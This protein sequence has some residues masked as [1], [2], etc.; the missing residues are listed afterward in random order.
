MA[1][2]RFQALGPS[3]WMARGVE[4]HFRAEMG[5][6]VRRRARGRGAEVAGPQFHRGGEELTPP[7]AVLGAVA[8]PL[9]DVGEQALGLNVAWFG[10]HHVVEDL[11]GPA[12]VARFEGAAG[13]RRSGPPG[14]A[15]PGTRSS[16]CASMT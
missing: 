6:D 5:D 4:E 8:E 1:R 9:E 3:T 16:S 7:G 10:K 2:S 11:S 12:Q 13:L 15:R 14:A